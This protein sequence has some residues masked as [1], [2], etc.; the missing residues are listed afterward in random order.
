MRFLK[1]TINTWPYNPVNGEPANVYYN[2]L[3]CLFSVTP[4]QGVYQA[5]S[6]R[7]GGEV[8]SADQY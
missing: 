2:S 6:T 5:L 4:T 3:T 7:A 8:V 1:D